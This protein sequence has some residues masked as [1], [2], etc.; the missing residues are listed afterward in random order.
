MI[1]LTEITY[2]EFQK[3]IAD[4][5]MKK[6]EVIQMEEEEREKQRAKYIISQKPE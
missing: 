2:Q 5:K 4:Y 1:G 6:D 3:I